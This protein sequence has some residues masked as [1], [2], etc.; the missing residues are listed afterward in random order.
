MQKTD[1]SRIMIRRQ[2]MAAP[3]GALGHVTNGVSQR[4]LGEVAWIVG[5]LAAPVREA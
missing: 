4:K 2:D 5:H 1:H 3:T